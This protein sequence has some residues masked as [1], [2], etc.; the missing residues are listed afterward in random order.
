MDWG[1]GTFMER[2]GPELAS[3]LATAGHHRTLSKGAP[4]FME[5]EIADRAA[6]VVE[7]RLKLVTVSTS[8]IESVLAIF[9]PGELVGEVSVFDQSPRSATVTA[10]DR[11]ELIIVPRREFEHFLADNGAAA[12]LLI[13]KLGVFAG[14][15]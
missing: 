7:G 8:G 10:L 3:R 13:W 2:L 14:R 12:L 4:L 5:G 1:S 11:A 15:T 9:G 6:V